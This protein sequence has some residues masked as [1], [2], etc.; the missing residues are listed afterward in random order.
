MSK[1]KRSERSFTFVGTTENV[2]NPDPRSRAWVEVDPK[3]IENNA[4]VLKNFIGENCLL[5]AVVKADGYGHGAETVAKAALIGGADSLGVATLEEGIQLRNSG[6][7]CQILILGNLINAEELYSAFFWDL[8]PTISGIRE[9]IICNNI[10]ENKN[11]KYIIHLKVDTGMTRLGCN[12]NEVKE[13]I[14][15]IDFLKNISL[16][17]IYSHLAIADEDLENNAQLGF[18]QIQL[19]RFEKVLK[20]LGAR[21]KLLC[22]H[23]ANSAG[24]LSDSRLHFDM[25]RVGLSLYGYFPVNDFDSD[26]KFHPA[27]KVKARVTLVREVAKGTGVGYGHFFKT[28]RKSKLAVVA[29]GY[30]DGVSRNLS[31][32]ISA[33]IDGVLVP[34]V[35]AIAM[36]QMVFDITDKPDIRTGQVLTLLGTDG[37]VCISPQNWCEFSGSIPWEVLCSFRNRLPRVVT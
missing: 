9:A 34:Q 18:T 13:L 35:G 12:C 6:L 37:E 16:K 15:R 11:K 1:I 5:M 20:D 30:A 33:S 22:R 27:L 21:N 14:S 8:I 24:T 19:T 2:M 32:K 29:I 31:G 3:A 26:L 23:L 25:V 28:Q 4:R 17:G 36:D 10:A 7:K